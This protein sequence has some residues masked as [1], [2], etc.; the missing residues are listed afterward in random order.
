LVRAKGEGKGGYRFFEPTMDAAARERH[1]LALDLRAAIGTAQFE[2]HYQPQFEV[3]SDRCCGFEALLR[4]THPTRGPIPPAH[5][6]PLAEE[7]GAILPLGEWVLREACREAAAW[8]LP[9]GIAVNI[10]IAQFRQADLCDVV[11]RALAETGLRPDRLELEVTESLFLKSSA[12]SQEVLG[13]LRALGVRVSMDDF[14]TGYSSLATLQAFPFDKI[15]IDRSFVGQVGVTNKGSA[16]VR[17]IISLG[18]SL[19]VPVIA[20][21]I[22]T[23][24]QL[25]FLRRHRCAEMQGYLRGKPRPIAEYRPLLAAEPDLRVA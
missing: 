2:L 18:E 19:G 5:F 21:G 1:E 3:A 6:V 23:E 13:D 11:R 8:E 15:K 14:G 9:L 10:S 12:R 7:T 4:W 25:A 20:E 17:A 16:I 24:E 22:E